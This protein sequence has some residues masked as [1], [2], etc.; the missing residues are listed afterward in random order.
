M[1]N[2]TPEDYAQLLELGAL[3]EEDQA[4]LKLVLAQMEGLQSG[5]RAP[6]ARQY[7]NVTVAL[8]W[9][10]LVGGLAQQ[11]AAMNKQRQAN[12]MMGDNRMRQQQQQALMLKALGAGQQPQQWPDAT[13]GGGL[14]GS[15][16][17]VR[18]GGM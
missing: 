10:E 9:M 13:D 16:S 6:Q 11:G 7:G 15:R 1:E 4:K 3:N 18:F 12:Q 2:L 8:H 17:A 14:L 5:A